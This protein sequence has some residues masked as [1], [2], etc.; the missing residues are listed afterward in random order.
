MI[1]VKLCF[2]CVL[3]FFNRFSF[4]SL[5]RA[6]FSLTRAA[7]ILII[8]SICLVSESGTLSFKSLKT[9]SH[10]MALSTWIHTLGYSVCSGYFIWQLFVMWKIWNVQLDTTWK[11]QILDSE[12]SV[13]HDFIAWHLP[14][15]NSTVLEPVRWICHWHALHTL[16]KCAWWV[17]TEQWKCST[18]H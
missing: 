1:N 9:F 12:T 15:S 4:F 5:I 6:G 16:W 8:L 11:Q 13:C 14:V 18:L 3:F 7:H 17:H 10:L 2:F